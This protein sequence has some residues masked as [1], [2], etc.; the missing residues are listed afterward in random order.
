MFFIG[1]MLFVVLVVETRDSVQPTTLAT[2]V[3]LNCTST[4]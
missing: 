3:T 4:I 1:L 2:V